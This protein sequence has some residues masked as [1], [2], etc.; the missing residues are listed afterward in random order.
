MTEQINQVRIV[1]VGTTHPGN[2]GAT[3]RAMKTMSQQQLYLVSPEIFPSAEA[4]ARATGADDLL[5]NATVCEDLKQAIAECN[6]VIGTTARD[7]SLSWP[8]WDLAECAAEVLNNH[9][10]QSAIIFGRES[11]GLSNG[12]LELCNAVMK[13]PANPD[14]ASLN[15]ASAV[16]LVCYELHKASPDQDRQGINKEKETVASQIQLEKFYGH[17]QQAMLETGYLNP[18]NPNKLMH[19][20]RRLFNRTRLE[21]SEVNLL[22]GFLSSITEGKSRNN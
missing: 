13:I 5:M 16:Q 7:R 6:L 1:L 17:L 10:H 11:S 14:Y 9:A 21:E 4:T 20:L 18:D 19:R 8:V 22:R 3:A 15:L 2:I 12:E